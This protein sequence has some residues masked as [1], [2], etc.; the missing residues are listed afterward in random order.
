MKNSKILLTIARD[1]LDTLIQYSDMLD[2]AENKEEIEGVVKEIM[3]DEFNHA[4]IAILMAAKVM[5]VKI[6]TDDISTNPNNIK[7]E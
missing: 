6:A 1:E 3:G 2:E 5:D 4:L 7:V